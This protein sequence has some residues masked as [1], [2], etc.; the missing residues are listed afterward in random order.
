MHCRRRCGAGYTTATA[1]ASMRRKPSVAAVAAV[2]TSSSASERGPQDE[3]QHVSVR[4]DSLNDACR[5][6]LKN[7]KKTNK[8]TTEIP[9]RR[10]L[11]DSRMV[12]ENSGKEKTRKGEERQWCSP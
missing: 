6:D 12:R 10:R 11:A 2:A 8:Q 9:R 4:I 1:T 7:A 3:M 5:R